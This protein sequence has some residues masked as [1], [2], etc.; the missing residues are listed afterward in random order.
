MTFD[1][2]K[3]SLSIDRIQQICVVGAGTLGAQIA[4]VAALHSYRV[5]LTD[6]NPVALEKAVEGNRSQLQNRVSK[7]KLSQRAAD[8]ALAR[9]QTF[10]SIEAA[11]GNADFVI[12]AVFEEVEVKRETFRKLDAIC[13][14]H[15][16]L[17]SNSSS[18]LIS[19]IAR[20]IKRKDKTVN[21]HFFHPALVM[22]LVEI[23]RGP[24]TSDETVNITIEL[25]KRLGKE[26]VLMNKAV[27]GC[28]INP[29]LIAEVDTTVRLYAEGHPDLQGSEKAERLGLVHPLDMFEMTDFSRAEVLH[30]VRPQPYRDSGDPRDKPPTFLDE[31]VHEGRPQPRLV[32]GSFEYLNSKVR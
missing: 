17:A 13:P 1:Q 8:E 26:T 10:T 30:F 5:N 24:E 28:I 15:T 21:M 20:D 7:G 31:M 23:V 14:A 2:A 25:G 22:Q 3:S 4:Q 29:A 16:I 6:V 18:L 12:E 9:V 19:Q 27:F 11:A 32:Q